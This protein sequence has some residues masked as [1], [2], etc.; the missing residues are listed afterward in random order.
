MTDLEQAQ[1]DLSKGG[2]RFT[3]DV[4]DGKTVLSIPRDKDKGRTWRWAYSMDGKGA[5]PYRGE[6]VQQLHC[7]E[8]QTALF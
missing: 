4:I 1:A 6:P 3:I 8:R 7:H 5:G 2:V